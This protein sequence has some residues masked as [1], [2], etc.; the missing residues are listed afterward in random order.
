MSVAISDVVVLYHM[1]IFFV[2]CMGEQAPTHSTISLLLVPLQKSREK[3]S[4]YP[5]S[6]ITNVHPF[7]TILFQ[8]ALYKALAPKLEMVP[9]TDPSSF[10]QHEVHLPR[11]SFLTY[12]RHITRIGSCQW[13]SMKLSWLMNDTPVV[14][15]I[16]MGRSRKP[17]PMI[18]ALR[19]A[20]WEVISFFGRTW[21][22]LRDQR[23]RRCLHEIIHEK[24]RRMC[25]RWSA[26]G[27]K[28]R[29]CSGS[30][31]VQW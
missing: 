31:W 25:H 13:M 22:R 8:F 15:Y 27:A 18:Q 20:T 2:S 28:G 5:I 9:Q 4:Q 30:L 24:F 12:A 11:V 10:S 14:P 7:L 21:D 29:W 6:H 16:K 17:M 1:A 19:F 26:K 23:L 3:V